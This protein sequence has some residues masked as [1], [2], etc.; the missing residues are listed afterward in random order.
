MK[1]STFIIDNAVFYDGSGK[2]YND[3]AIVVKDYIITATGQTTDIRSSYPNAEFYDVGS[4]LAIPGLVNAHH[5]LYSF[6]TAGLA[7]R[8]T[9]GTFTQT[10]ENLWWPFDN[11]LDEESVYWSGLMGALDSASY[12][13]TTIF[14]HHASMNCVRG[15]LN[16]IK[17]AFETAGIR[18]VLCFETSERSGL[19]NIQ[20][21]IDENIDFWRA[22]L[23]DKH[24]KGMFGMHANMTLSDKTLGAIRDACPSNMPFHVHCAES[25]EDYAFCLNLGYQGTVDRLMSFG[26]ITKMSILVHCI[27]LSDRDA[28]ILDEIQPFVVTNAESN[29]NNRVGKMNRLRLPRHT[30]GTD[31]MSG[32]MLCALRSYY[33]LDDDKSFARMSRAFF[34]TRVELLS[35]FFPNCGDFSVGSAADIAVL[36]Y[37]PLTPIDNN[38]LLGHLLFGA[39]GGKA[40]M[41][42]ADGRIIWHNGQFIGLDVYK[43]SEEARKAAAKLHRRYYASR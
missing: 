17:K 10:L 2:F 30:I 6:F 28:E 16:T 18:G 35:S 21:H 34:D 25:L 15:S 20:S 22:N 29:A 23:D 14:D 41:T 1:N 9:S 8:A 13:V 39:K 26:L 7:P 3:G 37:R 24:I 40:F 5:H 19:S 27:H 31:G 32:D 43:L 4:R 38:N 11:A 36:D 33:L 42:V 12:G